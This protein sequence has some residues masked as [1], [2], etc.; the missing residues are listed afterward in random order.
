MYETIKR[1]KT[2]ESVCCNRFRKF[3]FTLRYLKHR[4]ENIQNYKFAILMWLLDFLPHIKAS[5]EAES[6]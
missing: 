2:S 5:T 6:I 4:G 3:H 1:R